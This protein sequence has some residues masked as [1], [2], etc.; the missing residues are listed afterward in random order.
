VRA[1]PRAAPGVE[2]APIR[3]TARV[4][5]ALIANPRSGTAPD[6]DEL[7]ERLRADGAAVS[8]VP[9]EAIADEHR[10]DL[11]DGALD[12][13]RAA[14]RPDRIV[15]AGGDGSIGPAA[16]CAARLR[17]AL[18]VVPAGTA[19][20][21]ARAKGLPLD[22]EPA[23]ALA[24]SPQARTARADL[25]MA[26]GRPF[27][28]AAAAGLSVVAAHTAKPHKSRLGALAYAIGAARAGLTAAPL[29]CVV[30]CDGDERFAGRAW[31]V[32]V[33]VTGAFGGGSEI[34]AT[35]TGEGLLDVAV[36]PAG[37]R[38]GLV[39]RA[40]GMRAGRLI[41]QAGVAHERATV[42]EVE[43]SGHSAFNVDGETCR[44]EPARFELDPGGFDLVTPS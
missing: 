8:W 25:G 12:A 19:N 40:F 37:S 33:G 43:I 13:L 20:D 22:L 4:R 36:V 32:V 9:I 29:R 21:F 42:I 5:L 28:N 6:P 31:Q 30:T 10:G 2:R 27:V 41:E 35:R 24:G 34:G 17:V 11:E 7:A 18:A 44:C 14:G 1:A 3:Q 26:G 39:R 16:L 23:C 38:A 15:V